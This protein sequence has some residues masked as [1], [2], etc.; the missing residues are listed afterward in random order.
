[1]KD[2]GPSDHPPTTMSADPEIPETGEAERRM[3]EEFSK[4]MEKRHHLISE[5]TSDMVSITTFTE[6]PIYLYVSPSHKAVL[7]YDP[8]DLLGKCPFDFIHPE[9]VKK[10]LPILLQYY[11]IKSRGPLCAAERPV[12]EKLVYRL[13]DKWDQWHYLETTGDLLEQDHILFVSRDITDK[14][15]MDEEL[16]T[17]RDRLIERIQDRTSELL[18]AN[19]LLE[20]EILER[21]RVQEALRESEEKYRSII[22]SLE[23]GYYEADL[24]GSFTYF[25]DSLCDILGYSREEMMGL[26]N[27]RYMS[28]ETAKNVYEAYN[29]V[30]RTGRPKK[31]FGYE[32]IRKDGEKRIV[33]V[34]VSL[35]NGSDGCPTGFSGIARDVTHLNG[36]RQKG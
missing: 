27:R 17:I 12:T 25:N 21:E 29:E 15:R 26:N 34:S 18:R 9:D 30:Y 10:L 19:A 6:K 28:K 20:A 7:G 11:D 16:R 4:E 3:V 36:K 13:R 35:M 33:Q 23:D 8:P 24:E 22:E 1:M 32:L 31:I 2:M 14:K 5:K